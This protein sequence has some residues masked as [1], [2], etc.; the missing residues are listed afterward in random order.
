MPYRERLS[1]FEEKVYSTMSKE[2]LDRLGIK[3]KNGRWIQRQPS[4][5]GRTREQFEASLQGPPNYR[6]QARGVT[7]RTGPEGYTPPPREDDNSCLYSSL[8]R[9]G[10]P[11]DRW[12]Q[13]ARDAGVTNVNSRSD[14]AAMID[15]W[16]EMENP[17]SQLDRILDRA[18]DDDEDKDDK[19]YEPTLADTFAPYDDQYQL[20]QHFQDIQ[21]D[22]AVKPPKL[23]EAQQD[24]FP[25]TD[26][27][28]DAA[29]LFASKYAA[30][31]AE[32]LGISPDRRLNLR[33]A[34]YEA[35]EFN[36]FA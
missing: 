30:D 25:N 16:Q 29:K 21:S 2:E 22:L 8:E 3:E 14:I 24:D 13:L 1:P 9:A 15:I 7:G 6:A 20:S 5:D 35:P 18:R 32:G 23:Y 36:P 11:K 34:M 26:D 4:W 33:N 27:Q 17:Q 19:D 31:V 28:K 10:I 12:N